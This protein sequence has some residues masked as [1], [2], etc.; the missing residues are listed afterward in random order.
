MESR[1]EDESHKLL[2][3]E[4]YTYN[5]FGKVSEY[6]SYDGD[7]RALY[8][9]CYYFDDEGNRTKPERYDGD[10]NLVSTGR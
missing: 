9:Y 10:G 4:R 3:F 7:G 6:T 5:S 8:S 1:T 2:H